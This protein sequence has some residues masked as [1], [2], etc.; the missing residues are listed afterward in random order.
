MPENKEKELL[1]RWMALWAEIDKTYIGFLKRWDLSLNAYWVIEYLHNHPQGAEPA[2]LADRINVM[3]Q[4]ITIILN[5][6]EKRGFLLRR[7][8]ELDHRR[9]I[10]RLSPDGELFAREVCDAMEQFDLES[11][12]AFTPAEK[13]DI[14]ENLGEIWGVNQNQAA[15]VLMGELTQAEQD[16]L[17]GLDDFNFD[18]I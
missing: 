10:I 12:S 7:E 1:R 13:N 17:S 11:L 15:E 14:A 3:R 9:R 18:D 8:S 5:D 16:A 6:L 2:E 4:L